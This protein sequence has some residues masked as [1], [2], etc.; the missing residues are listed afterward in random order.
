MTDKRDRRRKKNCEYAKK[1]RGERSMRKS[2]RQEKKRQKRIGS[3]KTIIKKLCFIQRANN[4]KGKKEEND[5]IEICTIYVLERYP[6][7]T[8]VKDRKE[9]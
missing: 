1:D 7:K 9:I 3:K 2:V 8:K 4:N 6:Q 5:G